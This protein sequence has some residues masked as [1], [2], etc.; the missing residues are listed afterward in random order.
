LSNIEAG[1]YSATPS[2]KG[3]KFFP[4]SFSGSVTNN[5]GWEAASFLGL[6]P[7]YIQGFIGDSKNKPLANVTVNIGKKSVKSNSSGFYGFSVLSAGSYTIKPKSSGRN[8]KPA[9]IK[10]TVTKKKGSENNNFKE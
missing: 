6:S 2:R 9:S 4:S 3:S 5:K 1:T 10:A 8:F 7:P